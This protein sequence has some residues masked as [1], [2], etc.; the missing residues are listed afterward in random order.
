MSYFLERNGL[1]LK[2]GTVPGAPS[3]NVEDAIS[4]INENGKSLTEE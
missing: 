2:R 4:F 3:P 1:A